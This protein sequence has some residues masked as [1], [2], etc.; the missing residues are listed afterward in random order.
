V[1]QSGKKSFKK[2][3]RKML[4]LLYEMAGRLRETSGEFEFGLPTAS[5]A[6][7]EGA[8]PAVPPAAQPATW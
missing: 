1:G 7:Q 5:C 8:H 2:T 3:E 6:V 4:E